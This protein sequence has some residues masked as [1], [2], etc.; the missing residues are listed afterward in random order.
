MT[1]FS[2]LSVE[3]RLTWLS[4]SEDV[5]SNHVSA[6]ITKLSCK[7]WAEL[8]FR[9]GPNPPPITDAKIGKVFHA[10]LSPFSFC[11]IAKNHLAQ[12]LRSIA[13]TMIKAQLIN[14]FQAVK[15]KIRPKAF[16]LPTTTPKKSRNMSLF[17]W[18]GIFFL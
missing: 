14:W 15:V 13:E 7:E 16:V 6:M 10:R 8:G 18:V 12:R 3:N 4:T 9:P 1:G 17:F 2:Y 11:V 5:R